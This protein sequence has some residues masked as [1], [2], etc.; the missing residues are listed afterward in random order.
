MSLFLALSLRLSVPQRF[1]Y[2]SAK[3][4]VGSDTSG[5]IEEQRLEKPRR[6]PKLF[7]HFAFFITSAAVVHGLVPSVCRKK[8]RKKENVPWIIPRQQTWMLCSGW[9]QSIEEH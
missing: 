5:Q 8:K 9:L 4:R 6:D 3:E 1:L 7:A 2:S